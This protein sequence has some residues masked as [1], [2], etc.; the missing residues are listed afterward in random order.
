MRRPVL[1]GLAVAAFVTATAHAE[2]LQRVAT[3]PTNDK[4]SNELGTVALA[5]RSISFLVTR[6]PDATHPVRAY[7]LFPGS[8]GHGNLSVE[9]GTW[10]YE[11]KGNFVVRARRHFAEPGA[12]AVV[13]DAPS[14]KQTAFPHAFRASAR[15]GEDVH[16]VIQA[17]EGAY[18]KL[19]WTFIGTSEGTIS[20]AYAA[21][22]LGDVAHRLV[23]TS[24]LVTYGGN[25]G[26]EL[27]EA[28]VAAVNVPVLWVHHENDPCKAT[29]YGDAKAIADHLKQ[30]LITVSGAEGARGAPCEARS[31]HGFAGRE[32]AV[33]AAIR[34]WAKDGTVTPRVT[35][36][37]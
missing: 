9:N 6:R 22:L 10:H 20:A 19:D 37:P 28:D 16:A 18:G 11:Q 27:T 1:A 4:W 8:P 12:L 3:D 21:R 36:G 26:R 2:T 29:R 23:L 32:I 17:V 7:L 13:I 33:I 31:Q 35:A 15:Y 34:T 14:D 5:G 30:P 24:S 25:Q